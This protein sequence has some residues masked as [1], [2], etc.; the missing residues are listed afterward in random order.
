[1]KA[2]CG[3]GWTFASG[4]S[5]EAFKVLKDFF[6]DIWLVDEADDPHLPTAFGAR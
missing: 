4:S 3:E 5:Q 1:L 2:I 6:D